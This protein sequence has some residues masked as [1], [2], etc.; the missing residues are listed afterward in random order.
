MKL[1]G[2]FILI[3]ISSIPIVTAQTGSNPDKT[4]TEVNVFTTYQPHS[5]EFFKDYLYIA[6]GNSLLIYNTSDPENP[7]I[8]NRFSDFNEPGRVLGLSISQDQLYIASGPGWIYVLNISDPEKPKRMYQINNLNFA[9]DVAIVGEYMY[10]ADENTGMLIFNLTDR[11]NPGLVGMFYILRSNVSGSLQGWG[12]MAVAVS[13]NYAFLSGQKAKGF[14]IIDVSNPSKPRE[15]FHSGGKNVYDISASDIGV[16]L[17]RADGTTQFDILNIS[18]PSMPQIVDGFSILESADRSAIAIHPSGNYIY[19]ASGSTWHIFKI[20][21]T[22]TPELSIE[23]PIPSA[24][25]TLVQ[26]VTPVK[27]A[28][29][30]PAATIINEEE[31]TT[32]KPVNYSII[33]VSIFIGSIIL[34][35]W[36][37]KH[38]IKR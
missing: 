4:L 30:I 25:I 27:T 36:A 5:A 26:T 18:N 19:A 28:N 10:I 11:K 9:N 37:W 15:V 29:I 23:K 2:L 13:G 8:I 31:K 32:G 24:T 35:Y 14:Y 1:L 17:A 33:I 12:G 22:L 38:K 7:R 21:G 6:D 34:F 3:L 16:Y 20:S